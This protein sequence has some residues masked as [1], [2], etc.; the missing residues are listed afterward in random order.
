MHRRPGVFVFRYT[1]DGAQSGQE[2]YP[3]RLSGEY[4]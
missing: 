4:R 1:G 3:S 2:E